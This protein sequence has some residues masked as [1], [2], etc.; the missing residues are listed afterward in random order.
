MNSKPNWIKSMTILAKEYKKE[1]NVIETS[2]G[3]NLLSSS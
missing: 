3:K 1:V 2:M